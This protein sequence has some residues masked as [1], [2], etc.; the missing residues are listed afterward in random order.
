MVAAIDRSISP[1]TI[2]SAM[3]SAISAF[4]EKLKVL[5]ASA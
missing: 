2:S 4:S 5:S 3:A 1:V